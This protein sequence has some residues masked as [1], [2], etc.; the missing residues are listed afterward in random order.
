MLTGRNRSALEETAAQ[1]GDALI[2]EADLGAAKGVARFCD[3]V[4]EEVPR[5]DVL[6]HN[7]GV[8]IYAP[9]FATDPERALELVRLNL[10]APIEISRR[11]LRLVP[12][13]GSLVAVSS[14][15]G[16]VSMPGMGVYTASKHA[17]NAYVNVLRMETRN[18]GIHVLSVCPGYV[19]TSFFGNL[20]QGGFSG[21]P[22]GRGR[23]GIT[24]EQCAEAVYRGT[25]RQ[26]RT[27]VVPRIGWLLV[28]AERLAPA[29]THRLL[30][31]GLSTGGNR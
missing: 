15:V 7:A 12:S 23:F 6:I 30:T 8:G 24:A 27:V 22:P 2:L 29:L 13:G 17:L 11:L 3:R 5:I 28:A 20:L 25:L 9:S 26:K 16:K 31:W 1:A 10:L 4:V 19:S 21:P 18:R 14:I